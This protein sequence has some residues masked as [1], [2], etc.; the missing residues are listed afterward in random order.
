MKARCKPLSALLC[1]ISILFLVP[2]SALWAEE[3]EPSEAK[4]LGVI[5]VIGTRNLERSASDLAVP[6]DVLDASELLRQGDTRMDSMMSRVIPSLNVAQEPISDGATFIRPVLLRGLSADST[7]VLVNGKRRHRGPII[8]FAPAGGTK[9]SHGVDLSSIPVMALDRIEVLRDNAAAQYGSDAVAGIVNL[10]LRDQPGLIFEASRGQYFDDDGDDVTLHGNIGLP[11]PGNGFVNLSAEY[12]QS[13]PTE[14]SVQVT[15][16]AE[17]FAAGNTLIPNPAQ[18]WGAPE[19]D[20]NWKLFANAGMG[21][22][23]AVEVY[24]FGGYSER[25]VEGGYYWRDPF[26][27]NEVF[28]NGW[29]RWGDDPEA[30][31]LDHHPLD[32]VTCPSLNVPTPG[33]SAADLTAFNQDLA[34]LPEGCFA[35][36][37]AFPA[38]F[39]P[40]FA[41]DLEDVSLAFGLRGELGG[42]LNY[43]ASAVYG[44]SEVDFSLYN[45]VNPQLA[46]QE[47]NIPT[48]Y[49]LGGHEE[50]DWTLNLDLSKQVDVAGFHSPLNVG[51]GVE[52]REEEFKTSPGEMNSW[53]IDYINSDGSDFD[54]SSVDLY[55]GDCQAYTDFLERVTDGEIRGRY[56]DELGVGS[57][58]APGFRPDPCNADE[59]DRS[60]IAAYVDF[61]ADVS[62]NL[63]MGI[64]GRYEDPQDFDS[65]IDGKISARYQASDSFALRGSVGTGFRVPTVGQAT[66]RTVNTVL[67]GG[68]LVDELTVPSSDPLVAG[69]AEPLDSEE[70]FS[71]GLGGVLAMGGWDVTVDFYRVEVDDRIS[72]IPPQDLSCLLLTKDGHMCDGANAEAQAAAIRDRMRQFEPAID[73]ISQVSWFAN[74]FDTKTEGI[75]VV[76][77]YPAEL[78]GGS[79]LFTIAANY[80]RT[81][82]EKIREGSPIAAGEADPYD[83][84]Y[85]QLRLIEE[86]TPKLRL[87][88]TADHQAGPWRIL[89][90]VRHYGSHIDVHAVDWTMG[91]MSDRT[92]VDLE[93]SY[94][95]MKN[96]T[97]TLGADNVFDE[98][99]SRVGEP[100]W[101]SDTPVPDPA[102]ESSF[103]IKYPEGA[104]FDTNGGFYYLKAQ[105]VM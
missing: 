68:R 70:S 5:N 7:L 69:I 30:L 93:V 65:N 79:T 55:S 44:R 28:T 61:E 50:E 43:D 14:R 15:G 88:L 71:I 103:G 26:N 34:N 99:A 41:A 86:G 2:S 31:V 90:R 17:Q 10:V 36:Q 78:F 80:N 42:G 77:T 11:L 75:D 54:E 92:L 66:L 16:A 74:D 23:E 91:R 67:T 13:D 56:R 22:S 25:V 18:V 64:A 35:F 87:S 62:E 60:T 47:E 101:L 40:I 72:K 33:L 96:L 51:V 27:R 104:P 12:N 8:S 4:Q 98:E 32:S 97:L 21:L 81:E 94:S 73:A 38:G 57:N 20:D 45:T 52:Y 3:S 46:M 9:G 63:L 102:T 1:A 53:M 49:K 58:G 29:P 100:S 39:R 95:L 82:V 76:A 89:S 59:S 83:P 105:L 37:S 6:V 84:A 19:I 24:T 85:Q 48:A